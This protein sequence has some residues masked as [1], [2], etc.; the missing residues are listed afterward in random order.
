MCK[1]SILPPL[2]KPPDIHIETI[3]PAYQPSK[4]ENEP[5]V[6]DATEPNLNTDFEEN[7]PQ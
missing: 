2:P 1:D 5:L 6:V 7:A 4:I 3:T